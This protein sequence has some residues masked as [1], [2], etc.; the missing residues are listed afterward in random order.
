M[1]LSKELRISSAGKHFYRYGL[2]LYPNGCTNRSKLFH[3]ILVF[4]ISLAYFIRCLIS[5]YW[6]QLPDKPFKY[7]LFIGDF[8]FFINLSFHLNIAFMLEYFIIIFTQILSYYNYVLDIR[9]NY[10]R[11]FD[12]MSAVITPKAIGLTD[13]TIIRDILK[14]SR[15]AFNCWEIIFKIS[16]IICFL[17][18]LFAFYTRVSLLDMLLIGLPHSLIFDINCSHIYNTLVIQITY[19]YLIAYYLRLKQKSVNNYFQKLIK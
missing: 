11:V 9:P 13:E 6:T 18:P 7:Y 3:P 5:I 2:S 14:R 19:F 15:I 10:M 12:M 1:L 16:I 4:T 8:A 17:F